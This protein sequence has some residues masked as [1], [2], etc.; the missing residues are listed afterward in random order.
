MAR[1]GGIRLERA[2]SMN[3]D[4][5]FIAGMADLAVDALVTPEPEPVGAG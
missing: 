3:D 4:P 5:T 2:R 1:E